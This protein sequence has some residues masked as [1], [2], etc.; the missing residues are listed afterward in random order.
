MSILRDALSGVY[1]LAGC[2]LIYSAVAMKCKVSTRSKKKKKKKKK[3]RKGGM[4]GPRCPCRERASVWVLQRVATR[5][6][7]ILGSSD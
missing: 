6:G 7:K 2:F 4:R 1:F 3:K 5:T